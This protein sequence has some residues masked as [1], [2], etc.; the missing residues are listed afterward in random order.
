MAF[1]SKELSVVISAQDDASKVLDGVG[2]T[3]E[4][5]DKKFKN[6]GGSIS[7]LGKSMTM[8]LTLPLTAVGTAAIIAGNQFD[9]AMDSIVAGTGVSGDAMLE[10]Q[11]VLKDVGMSATQ[12]FG[13]I[14]D[15]IK[16]LNQRLGLT[17]G[18]LESASRAVLTFARV[19]E[20]DASS[21]VEGLGRMLK[22]TGGNV[23]DL[24]M[25]LDQLTL[26]S[27]KSGANAG[28]LATMVADSAPAFKTLGFSV[29]QTIALLA[30]L[31]KS[32]AKPEEV[33]M[34]MGRALSNLSSKGFKSA[35]EA[36]NSYIEKIKKAPTD[37]EAVSI[38]SDLFGARAGYKLAGQIRAGTFEIDSMVK[39]LEN[40]GGVLDQTSANTMSFNERMAQMKNQVTLALQPL[41]QTMLDIFDKMRPTIMSVIDSINKLATWFS[42]L[43]PKV[44]TAIVAFGAFLAVIGPVLVIVGTLISSIGSI[45]TAVGALSGVFAGIGTIFAGVGSAIGAVVAVLGGPLTLIIGA[46]IG[47][48]A[49]L[50]LA[51]T[52]NW[53]GIQEKVG[54]FVA[55]FSGTV[56]PGIMTAFDMIK[57]FLQSLVDGFILGFQAV[58][59]VV[60]PFVDWFSTYLLPI[61]QGIFALLMSLVQ[62]WAS[63]WMIAFQGIWILIQQFASWFMSNVVPVLSA[64]FE[65][66][67]SIV[68]V[69]VNLWMVQIN[70]IKNVINIFVN[71]FK[72]TIVPIF[73][74]AFDSL[75]SIGEAWVNKWVERFNFVKGII[76]GVITTFQSLINKAR[77]AADIAV[78]KM[79]V[80]SF[81]EGGFVPQ[82]GLA[83]LHR[84]E[85]VA[86]TD[87]LQGRKSVP[88][89]VEQVFNQPINIQANVNDSLDMNLLGDRVAFAL[90]NSR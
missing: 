86:S 9:E 85:F 18:E 75:I 81:Q 52:Q 79:N 67:K 88:S 49:L 32:G 80:Q 55:W 28:N 29:T 5:L 90:R 61:F 7:S 15:A 48:I 57:V 38:A 77:E 10:M 4:G 54:A 58:M 13:D 68:M 17:G 19:N 35:E 8:G 27:Q 65:V 63:A 51:W 31:E 34:S 20:I 47:L 70:F 16:G 40:A 74:S 78:G 26:A 64:G 83:L 24:N 1:D 56:L 72:D 25:Y 73:S 62:I 22:A 21:A 60:Q 43:D 37:L 42:N 53:F 66:L 6:V 59:L 14:A 50:T 3:V 33:M 76:E 11:G 69:W 84:G 30:Q 89:S 71:W 46:I 44:S 45:I 41:G 39:A 12:S 2:T 87:M 36:L 82:T 23:A